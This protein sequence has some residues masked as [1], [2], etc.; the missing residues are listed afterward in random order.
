MAAQK[1]DDQHEH[2]F[3]SYVRIQDVVLKT[4]LGRW[5]KGRSGERGSGISVLPARYDDDDD[6]IFIVIVTMFWLICCLAVIHIQLYAYTCG[7]I[8]NNNDERTQ[9]FRK[10]YLSHFIRNG[11]KRVMKGLCVRGELETE[12]TAT[13]WPPVPLPLAALLSHSAGLLNRGSWGSIALCWV[14][15]L[16]TASY[17][18]LDWLQL[19]ELPVAPGYI[20]VWC[21]P[22]SCEHR[23]CTQFNPS[24]VMVIPWYLRLDAPVPWLTAGS[25]VNMLQICPLAFFRCFMSNFGVHTE[26]QTEPFI[27]TTGIKVSKV[28][29]F[30]Q[31]RPEG[32]LF[33]MK[34]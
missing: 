24:T 16:P 27:W 25:K 31:G 32:S 18:Q 22:A 29:D 10:T 15:V 20:I 14:L 13:Y 8:V 3:S 6:L 4:Y 26:F 7:N 5:T 34:V 23:I 12:Q 11:C 9:F 33:Y 1:Q 19:T 17:L 2:T 30:S 21:P 28:G